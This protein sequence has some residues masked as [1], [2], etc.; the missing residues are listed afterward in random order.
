MLDADDYSDS[1][2]LQ[3]ESINLLRELNKCY[4]AFSPPITLSKDR[5]I[6]DLPLGK[7]LKRP[8]YA[9]A[10]SAASPEPSWPPSPVNKGSLDKS[11]DVSVIG[12]EIQRKLTQGSGSKKS[13]TD[14]STPS[15]KD[16]QG[17]QERNLPST[18]INKSKEKQ[19]SLSP[20]TSI[21]ESS[22]QTAN[23]PAEDETVK[24]SNQ[25]NK[26]PDGDSKYIL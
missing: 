6:P 8:L 11:C 10:L 14:V 18:D 12:K 9:G 24:N 4:L 22:K 7:I 17:S 23:L 13:S 25:E 20:S 16:S 3:Y 5:V 1:W 21:K 19:L 26:N 2:I 15:S